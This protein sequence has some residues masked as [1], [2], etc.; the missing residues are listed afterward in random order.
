[1]GWT[2]ARKRGA[3]GGR[4][5]SGPEEALRGRSWQVGEDGEYSWEPGLDWADSGNAVRQPATRGRPILGF[6]ACLSLLSFLVILVV[7]AGIHRRNQSEPR[8]DCSESWAES[9]WSQ[10]SGQWDWTGAEAEELFA[11]ARSRVLRAA[12]G[13]GALECR[14]LV[15]AVCA[16]LPKLRLRVQQDN[17]AFKGQHVAVRSSL[18]RLC[19]RTGPGRSTVRP[20]WAQM[21]QGQLFVLSHHD[22][23]H[24]L[25]GF[26]HYPADCPH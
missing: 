21:D 13:K 16:S 24:Q 6:L 4:R 23:Y 3:G 10:C 20:D 2:R 1:M 14:R 8:V 17:G 18:P 25:H 22:Y 15:T 9:R 11:T 26:T 5:W 19:R 7:M 12:S